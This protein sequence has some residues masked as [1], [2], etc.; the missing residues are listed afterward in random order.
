MRRDG[1]PRVRFCVFDVLWALS[2]SN[3]AF[4]TRLLNVRRALDSVRNYGV[5]VI[6]V[7]HTQMERAS[8]VLDYESTCLARG[9]EGVMLRDPDG[10]YKFG[11]STLREGTLLKLKRFEDAEA[12]VI[13]FE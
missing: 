2:A 13:G 9:Y 8:D 6:A 5:E 3:V 4:A 11:R 12:V 10:P 7:E 1:Q